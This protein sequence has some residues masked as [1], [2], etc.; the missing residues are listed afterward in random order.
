M[1]S[2]DSFV[3][4]SLRVPVEI[5]NQLDRYRRAIGKKRGSAVT[6]STA[7]REILA[8]TLNTSASL[9]HPGRDGGHDAA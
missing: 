1:P 7:V 2:D 8:T 6:R 4:L 3:L 5:A 9:S